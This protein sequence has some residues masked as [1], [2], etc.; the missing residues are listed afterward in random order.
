MIKDS[1][2]GIK[3]KKIKVRKREVLSEVLSEVFEKHLTLENPCKQREF[4]RKSEV[5]RSF[6]KFYPFCHQDATCR[7]VRNG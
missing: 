1:F 2:S 3:Y 6:F 4:E 7:P 5:V